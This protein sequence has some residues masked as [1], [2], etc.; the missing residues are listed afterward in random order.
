M[1][2]REMFGCVE[3]ML[4][5][6]IEK[7]RASINRERRS[8]VPLGAEGVGPVGE[9]QHIGKRSGERTDAVFDGVFFHQ[10]FRKSQF[11]VAVPKGNFSITPAELKPYASKVLKS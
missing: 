6:V 4:N 10:T 8:Y 3:L 1:H 11:P 2:S 7:L 5:G 9:A